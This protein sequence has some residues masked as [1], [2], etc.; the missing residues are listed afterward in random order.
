MLIYMLDDDITELALWQIAMN[1]YND[2]KIE[3]FQCARK[4]KDR[5]LEK[6]PD[7]C[8]IDFVLPYD[9][10]HEVCKFV[11]SIS[12]DTKI[13]VNTGLLGDEYNVLANTCSAVYMCK[14]E[15]KLEDRVEAVINDC[16]S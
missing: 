12:N 4:F 3:L 15:M 7:A 1:N 13:F 8:I 11:R 16:R 9:P 5:V 10:G 2:V 6:M 14:C